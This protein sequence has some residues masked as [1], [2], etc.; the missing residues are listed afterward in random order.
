MGDEA[1]RADR[2]QDAAVQRV[3]DLVAADLEHVRER[4]R[5]DEP[6]AYSKQTRA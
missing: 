4:A 3:A 2:V 6:R 5:L 1:V